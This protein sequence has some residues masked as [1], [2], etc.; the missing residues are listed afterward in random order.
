ML[1]NCC[2][3]G[4]ATQIRQSILKIWAQLFKASDIVS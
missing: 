4:S 3:S 1:E 2:M